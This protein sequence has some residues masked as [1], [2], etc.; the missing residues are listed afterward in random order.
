[1]KSQLYPISAS[2]TTKSG[3]FLPRCNFL[4]TRTTKTSNKHNNRHSKDA[5]Q[6]L[7]KM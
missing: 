1:M 4:T 2:A 6:M 7:I 5:I 3:V